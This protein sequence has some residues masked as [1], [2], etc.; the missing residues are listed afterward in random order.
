MLLL[1]HSYGPG[2]M[3]M[4]HPFKYCLANASVAEGQLNREKS[5]STNR[6]RKNLLEI[7][8]FGRKNF[9]IP[10]LI[11]LLFRPREPEE[12]APGSQTSQLLGPSVSQAQRESF[13][14]AN[15]RVIWGL[16][17][18][19]GGPAVGTAAFPLPA[20]HGGCAFLPPDAEI[21][22]SCP[23]TVSGTLAY[24]KEYREN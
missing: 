19:G 15:H 10:Q 22:R 21:L 24:G 20:A 2:E 3:L 9:S 23:S 1:N 11:G 5:R 13:G 17:R 16:G 8:L 12:I 7:T 18:R 4:S 6:P 14:P